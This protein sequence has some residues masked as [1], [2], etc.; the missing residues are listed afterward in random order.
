MS[1]PT[2]TEETPYG[3]SLRL[4]FFWFSWA[5]PSQRALSLGNGLSLGEGLS[6]LPWQ[7]V[8]PPHFPES[9]IELVALLRGERLFKNM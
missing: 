7:H 8:G 9:E 3:L 4:G 2:L 1:G 6:S 5:P